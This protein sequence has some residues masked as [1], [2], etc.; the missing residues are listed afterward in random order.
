MKW[1]EIQVKTSKEAVDAVSNI[2]YE[3]GANGVVIED[4]DVDLTDFDWDYVDK[5]LEASM[6]SSTDATVKCYFSQSPS[7]PDKINLIKE[8]VD[9]LIEYDLDKGPGTIDTVEV[10]DEEW[11]N[12]KKYYKPMKIGPEIVIKP[13]WEDYQAKEGEKIVELDPGMAFGTGT[14]ETTYMCINELQKYI[15]P[16]MDVIDAGCGSG[17]LSITAARLGAGHVLALDKDELAV[18]VAGENVRLNHLTDVVEVRENNLLEGIDSDA[19]IIVAN[20]VADVIIRLFKEVGNNLR[21]GGLL[22]ASGII[23]E[24]LDDVMDGAAGSG[25][26]LKE[27]A[28]MGDWVTLIFSK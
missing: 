9:K 14:H 4:N 28:E 2:L 21:M 18:K 16:G 13:Q 24:R 17:I 5:D 12:W 1:V 19:D 7:L 27:K 20:I 25:L 26:A 15:R 11:S 22:I 10:D 8:R 23:K 6:Q 3:L